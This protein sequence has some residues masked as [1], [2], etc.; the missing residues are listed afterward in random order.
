MA[1]Y[2]ADDVYCIPG[3]AVLKNKAGITDQDQLDEYEGDFTA[4]RLLEL[5][6]NPVEGSFDLAHLCKIHQYLF[7]DV[8]EWAGEVRTVDIIRGDSRFCNVRQIQF[9][10]N[11]V[12]SALAAEKY[13]RNLEA[14]VFAKRLA[15]YLS[16]INAVHP[17]REGNGRV[18]RLFISQLAEHAGYSLDYSAL[19]QAELYPCFWPHDV[20]G[21]MIEIVFSMLHEAWLWCLCKTRRAC[22]NGRKEGTNTPCLLRRWVRGRLPMRQISTNGV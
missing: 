7:Q 5:T 13:L 6:Q 20:S 16:E 8:Y 22:P 10:S 9:Y 19:E 15:H 18:Q 2:D 14:T 12:F 4:I 3:T 11:T 21:V 17:F 1:R